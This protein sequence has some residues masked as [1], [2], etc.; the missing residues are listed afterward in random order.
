MHAMTLRQTLPRLED[1]T[2]MFAV[3]K[4]GGILRDKAAASDCPGL[5]A[6]ST[7]VRLSSTGQADRCHGSRTEHNSRNYKMQAM[8]N[9]SN[10]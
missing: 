6:G 3:F 8:R 2:Q 4:I 1:L 7:C 5:G 9:N 10:I